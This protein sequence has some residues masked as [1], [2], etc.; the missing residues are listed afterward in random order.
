[1]QPCAGYKC[2]ERITK[3]I[4]IQIYPYICVYIYILLRCQRKN[5]VL[6]ISQLRDS[7]RAGINIGN[8]V[9]PSTDR[10]I[11]RYAQRRMFPD[12]TIAKRVPRLLG[13]LKK[14]KTKPGR[15]GFSSNAVY[16]SLYI[17]LPVLSRASITT[18]I[19]DL[20]K[21]ISYRSLNLRSFIKQIKLT[22]PLQ[23]Q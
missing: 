19:T 6:R 4:F 14:K 1:M 7:R 21:F 18:S 9:S 12:K 8:G 11:M 23:W 10:N 13:K 3:Q 15:A 2:D 22:C 20:E 16:S 5:S 17:V